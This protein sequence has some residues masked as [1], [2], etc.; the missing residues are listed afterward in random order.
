MIKKWV[1][2]SLTSFGTLTYDCVIKAREMFNFLPLINNSVIIEFSLLVL[3]ISATRSS[4]TINNLHSLSILDLPIFLLT[5]CIWF[6]Y[7]I[8]ALGPFNFFLFLVFSLL[9]IKNWYLASYGSLVYKYILS[10]SGWLFIKFNNAF[11]FSDPKRP[12]ISILNGWYGIYGD[13][14]S[15]SVF[16][17]FHNHRNYSF[18]FYLASHFRILQL[19]VIFYR[20]YYLV[21]FY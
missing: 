8:K 6:E 12:I 10:I 19:L 7:S 21:Q 17:Y 5:F 4:K 13:F 18:I 2:F 15:C 11:V 3:I 20:H 1:E 9:L 16:F 14:K